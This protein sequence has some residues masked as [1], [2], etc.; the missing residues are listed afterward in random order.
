MAPPTVGTVVALQ[1]GEIGGRLCLP[2]V[3]EV[4]LNVVVE[5]RVRLVVA[6][7]DTVQLWTV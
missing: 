1:Q 7:F 5:W 6:H 2:E 4:L 3:G